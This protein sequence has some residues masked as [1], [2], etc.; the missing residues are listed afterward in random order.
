M[1]EASPDHEERVAD[2]YARHG[3]RAARVTT[4]VESIPGI[5]GWSE[6]YA[7]DGYTLRCD[8]SIQGS[9]EGMKYSE[10]APA[11]GPRG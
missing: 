4:E 8:W 1:R 6:V 9:Y 10:L 11:A 7:A 3:G 2:F 5:Q